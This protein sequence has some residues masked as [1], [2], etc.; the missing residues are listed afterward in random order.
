MCILPNFSVQD[1]ELL[2]QKKEIITKKVDKKTEKVI[3]ELALL[4]NLI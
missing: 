4:E 2:K 1:L 3:I